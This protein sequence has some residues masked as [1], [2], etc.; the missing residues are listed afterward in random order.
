[1]TSATRWLAAGA[2]VALI[3]MA[4][5]TSTTAHAALLKSNPSKGATLTAPPPHLQL[6]FNEKIDVAVSMIGL[7]GPAGKVVL[8]K[9]SAIEATSLKVV[10]TGDMADGQYTVAWQAAGI[11]GH[12]EKGTFTF[13]LKR[14]H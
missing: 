7:T 13:A 5:S 1:M 12:P 8:G 6:W 14:A 2:C 3:A 9:P 11:D 4:L 10:V